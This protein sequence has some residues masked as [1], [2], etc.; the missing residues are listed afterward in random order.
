MWQDAAR[1]LS[2]SYPGFKGL[3]AEQVFGAAVETIIP[4]KRPQ[5]PEDIG[6]AVVFL[7]SDEARE[8]T[9]QA[10]NIDGGAVFS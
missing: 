8:I 6:N 1:V 5:T 7:A 4:M 9:G 10:L 2:M 3:P